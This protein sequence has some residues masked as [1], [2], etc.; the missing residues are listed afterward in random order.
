MSGA[1]WIH[2]SG[3]RSVPLAGIGDWPRAL[4]QKYLEEGYEMLEGY[5]LGP[6]LAAQV[7]LTPD[8]SFAPDNGWECIEYHVRTGRYPDTKIDIYHSRCAFYSAL[9]DWVKP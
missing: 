9:G 8:R 7:W 2:K 5:G 1:V 3:E 4:E 6:N